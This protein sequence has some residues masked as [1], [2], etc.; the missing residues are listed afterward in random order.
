M[1]SG[2]QRRGRELGGASLSSGQENMENDSTSITSV[3]AWTW[4]DV[5]RRRGDCL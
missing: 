2:A 3:K 5:H 4:V 1:Q